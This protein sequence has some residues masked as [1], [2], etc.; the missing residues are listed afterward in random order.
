MMESHCITFTNRFTENFETRIRKYLIFFQA[1]PAPCFF[2]QASP[3]PG[4]F[5][6]AAPAHYIFFSGSGSLIIFF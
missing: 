4:F 5:F 6:Q 1:A 3:A 2:F